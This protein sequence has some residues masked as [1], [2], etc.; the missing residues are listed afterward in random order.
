[1]LFLS[2]RLV[3]VT[4]IVFLCLTIINWSLVLIIV[5]CARFVKVVFKL[6]FSGGEYD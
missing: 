2:Y 3:F 1:M 5:C 6:N 4:Q